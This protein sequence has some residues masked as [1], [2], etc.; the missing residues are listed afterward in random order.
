M[1]TFKKMDGAFTQVS[2]RVVDLLDIQELG[3]FVKMLRFPANWEFSRTMLE[4]ELGVGKFL[5]DRIVRKLKEINVLRIQARRLDNGSFEGWEWLIWGTPPPV[6]Q[7]SDEPTVGGTDRRD[8]RPSGNHTES[9]KE[10]KSKKETKNKSKETNR[11]TRIPATFYPS[12]EMIEWAMAKGLGPV[13]EIETQMFKNYWESVPG[14]R[15]SKI[16][17]EK[18]WQNRMLSVLQRQPQYKGD[19]KAQA[20]QDAAEIALKELTQ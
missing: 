20:S 18:T 10:T 14:Q 13:I 3:A 2:N 12:A 19:S 15:G 7:K 1:A 9:I 8:S 4:T 5:L 16:S 11:G 17:W 6:A